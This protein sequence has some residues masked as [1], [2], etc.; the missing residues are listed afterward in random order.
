MYNLKAERFIMKD[1]PLCLKIVAVSLT[2]PFTI[3]IV[4]MQLEWISSAIAECCCVEFQW[5][6]ASHRIREKELCQEKVKHF[7]LI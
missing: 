1:C 7:H 3:Y 5:H 2:L 4:I 6:Y